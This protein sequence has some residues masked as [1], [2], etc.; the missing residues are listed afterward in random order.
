MK[1]GWLGEIEPRWAMRS[2]W[3]LV[4]YLTVYC[5]CFVVDNEDEA[6]R[7]DMAAF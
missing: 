6:E 7:E 1:F 4:G 3:H 2:G 5:V